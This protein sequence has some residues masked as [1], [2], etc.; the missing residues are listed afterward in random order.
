MNIARVGPFFEEWKA[1]RSLEERPLFLKLAHG[2]TNNS[3]VLG[4]LC[5]ILSFFGRILLNFM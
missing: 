5:F 1:N 4:G 3:E 2:I